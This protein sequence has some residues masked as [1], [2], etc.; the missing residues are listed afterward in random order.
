[1]RHLTAAL[2]AATAL[3]VPAGALAAVHETLNAPSKARAGHSIR[4]S[5][6]HWA[7]IE[8]CKPSVDIVLRGR[9]IATAALDLDGNFARSVHIPSSA[10]LGRTR[11]VAVQHCE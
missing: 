9:R 1:M 4:V 11:L 8:F 10:A 2:I 3:A 5:G 6:R 7:R